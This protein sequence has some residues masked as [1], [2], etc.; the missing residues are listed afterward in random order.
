MSTQIPNSH[1]DLLGAPVYVNLITV[2]PDGQPQA[3][4]VWCSYDGEHVLVN[5]AVG[6]QK[7]INM[8]ERPMVTI[9]AVDPQNPFRYL[10]VR[11]TVVTV[12]EEGALDHINALAKAYRNADSYYG[13]VTP[14][15]LAQ[16]ETRVI[17][18][19][20]PTKVNSIG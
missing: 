13:G 8:R 18:K 11:G 19:I 3:S 5:T 16:K 10:E 14:A 9:L 17:G 20:K 12:T 1:K 7:E 4:V 6:R 15:E 2:M